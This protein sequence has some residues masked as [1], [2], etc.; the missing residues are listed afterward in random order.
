MRVHHLVVILLS[1][2]LLISRPANAAQRVLLASSQKGD[3]V[4]PVSALLATPPKNAEVAPEAPRVAPATKRNSDAAQGTP[5]VT[6]TPARNGEAAPSSIA[7]ATDTSAIVISVAEQKLYLFNGDGHKVASYRVSTSKFGLGDS[8]ASYATPL[9]Q[10]AVASKIGDGCVPGTV[11]HHCR[12]T[13][14]VIAPN[15]PGR[16]PIVT[17][18]LPLRGLEPQNAHAL[19]RGIYIHGTPEERNIG[20]PASYG[21]VRMKSRDV[22]D[23]FDQVRSGTRV[24]ITTDRVASLFG[25]VTRPALAR[26]SQ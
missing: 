10:F 9:G 12:P 7:P 26:G 16:D 24:E 14:E 25:N 3:A 21:C 2:T 22:L 5:R 1:Q 6:A 8:R 11:F 15:A 20:R 19:S 23:L 18:I 13:G 4:Q 17:R